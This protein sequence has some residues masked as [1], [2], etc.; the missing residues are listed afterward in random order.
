MTAGRPDFGPDYGIDAPGLVRGFAL[1][2]G[3]LLPLA[4]GLWWGV[5]QGGLPVW[6]RWFAGVAAATGGYALFMTG[7]MIWGSRVG[8]V[9]GRE[10]ILDLAGWTGREQV[11]DVGCGRGLMTVGA[12]RRLD[13][14]RATG[15]D[16]WLGRDQSGNTPA[17][18]LANAASEG[19]ADRVD[20]RTAD[21]R[22]LPFAD[23]SFDIVLSHWAIHNL[24][25]AA[26]RAAALGEVVRVLRPGGTLLLTD[27][28]CRAE[29][30][31]TLPKLG[32]RDV[33]LHVASPPLDLFYAAVSFGSF[34]PA[35]VQGRAGPA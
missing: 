10:A 4:L 32:L 15:I 1:G 22:A 27:I 11:L 28:A 34:R 17:A 18:L 5:A 6:L 13:G 33:A 31:A 21:M 8:K 29:Y 20:V 16:V 7:L 35:T 2:A 14:G 23:D 12:A 3:T 30:L 19:V 25:T 9:R 24:S 26:D